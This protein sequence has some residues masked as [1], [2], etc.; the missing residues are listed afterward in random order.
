MIAILARW[1]LS[2]DAQLDQ[3]V[4]VLDASHARLPEGVGSVGETT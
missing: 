1:Q 4:R 3:S 2:S